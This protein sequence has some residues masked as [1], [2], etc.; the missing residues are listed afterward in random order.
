MAKRGVHLDTRAV[1]IRLTL[2]IFIILEVRV[3]LSR[4]RLI[5]APFL[6]RLL[7]FLFRHWATPRSLIT[8]PLI[9]AVATG[10]LYLLVRLVLDP[11]VRSWHTPWTDGSAGLFH[12]AANERVLASSPGR[13]A[14]GRSWMPGTLVRTNL[15]LWFFPRAHDADIWSRPLGALTEIHLEPA[16]R[17]VWGYLQG[18]PARVVLRAADGA[19]PERFAV[20]DP[21]GVLAWF[22]PPATAAERAELPVSSP[23]SR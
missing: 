14:V 5:R 6:I 15:R 17:R 20:A 7:V 16:P 2:I 12:V 11:L 1:F 23:R 4:I 13:H 8:A 3:W 10:V 19:Q 21:E 18:W 9:A 22:E